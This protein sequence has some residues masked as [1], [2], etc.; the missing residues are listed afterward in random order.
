MSKKNELAVRNEPMSGSVAM[1]ILAPQQDEI[2]EVQALLNADAD[3]DNNA[4]QLIPPRIKIAPGGV[5][6]FIT[7]DGETLDELTGVIALAQKK[8]GYW[9][10]KNL[11]NRP[12]L[13]S[14]PEG[15]TGYLIELGTDDQQMFK[16]AAHAFKPHSALPLLDAEQPLPE[17][18]SCYRCPLSK[19]GSEHQNG[20]GGPGKACKEM[21]RLI[22]VLDGY[23]EPVIFSLPPTSCKPFDE[24]A[25]GIEARGHKYYGVRVRITQNVTKSPH[26]GN[27]YGIAEFAL[28]GYIEEIEQAR[29]VLAVRNEYE[30]LVNDMAVAVDEYETVEPEAKA[31]AVEV[32]ATP[33][34]EEEGVPF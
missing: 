3:R 19:W 29:A 18:Y 13:C 23:S 25:S 22:L 28:D 34:E 31:P 5:G 33:K 7:D 15:D 1:Q 11:S 27:K 30:E 10:S 2:S 16:D 12:P 21:R 4:F 6:K 8:R 24:F 32:E 14:S 20:N 26:N 17:K 9:P